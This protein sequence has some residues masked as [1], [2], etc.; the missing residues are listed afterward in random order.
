M[1]EKFL[2][3]IAKII[4]YLFNFIFFSKKNFL[5]PKPKKV[6]IYNGDNSDIILKA[7]VN[8]EADVIYNRF[9]RAGE[10]NAEINFFILFYNFLHFRFSLFEYAKTYIKF[11]K[12]KVIITIIDN[13]ENFYKLKKEFTYIKFVAI[14]LSIRTTQADLF[15][16]IEF[17]KKKNYEC[18]YILVYNNF[19]GNYYQKFLKGKVIKIGSFKS[20]SVKVMKSKKKKYDIL[21]V[22][23]YKGNKDSDFFLKEYNVKYQDIRKYDHK[24]FCF[25]KK[26][27]V[28]NP[29]IKL[30]I[31]GCKTR[32]KFEE[33][34]YFR[35]YFKNLNYEFIPQS[36]KRNTYNIIDRTN[37]LLAIDSSL[38]YES[39]ARGNKVCVLEIEVLI[40]H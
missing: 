11:S 3:K 14:Q 22:S 18:D 24:I 25:L 17:L 31:L 32:S 4:N 29:K 6:L 37:L 27:L 19:F 15:G 33:I 26:I 2:Q 36:D 10:K 35:N 5:S 40:T 39:I 38:I 9:F 8:I 28:E 13:D 23:S 7:L 34:K 30:G 21:Y 20:N 16:R 12:P 1:I